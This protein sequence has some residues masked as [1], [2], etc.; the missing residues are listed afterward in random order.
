MTELASIVA[1]EQNP[2]QYKELFPEWSEVV[3]P[4][5]DMP[6]GN[7]HVIRSGNMLRIRLQDSLILTSLNF[8]LCLNNPWYLV[9]PFNESFS[10]ED[11]DQG[12]WV[13]IE[14]FPEI[15]T[16]RNTDDVLSIYLA[17]VF[18]SFIGKGE[19]MEMNSLAI[20][21]ALRTTWIYNGGRINRYM[22]ICWLYGKW[23]REFRKTQWDVLIN[24]QRVRDTLVAQSMNTEKGWLIG[25]AQPLSDWIDRIPKVVRSV[26]PSNAINVVTQWATQVERIVSPRVNQ[27]IALPTDHWIDSFIKSLDGKS[28]TRAIKLLEK[29]ISENRY[30]EGWTARL[31]SI[32]ETRREISEWEVTLT[33]NTLANPNEFIEWLYWSLSDQIR[34]LERQ[35][36]RG[37]RY[38]EVYMAHLQK[39]KELLEDRLARK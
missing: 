32:L 1:T 26:T 7:I 25:V 13:N 38:G 34:Q 31:E 33:S 35:L 18:S 9:W 37:K 3:I 15:F 23:F 39:H 6:D 16:P 5:G 27:S 17:T 30:G 12:S 21:M 22:E 19:R 29:A 14:I 11:S 20:A 4:I 36:K 24:S 2:N 8:E 28:P 10:Y